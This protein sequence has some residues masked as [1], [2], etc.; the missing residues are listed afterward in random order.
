MKITS[1]MKTMVAMAIPLLL[2]LGGGAAP[3]V[4]ISGMGGRGEAGV[5]TQS[6]DPCTPKQ[7]NC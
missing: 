3:A 6:P 7:S 1:P 2:A 4:L 5:G